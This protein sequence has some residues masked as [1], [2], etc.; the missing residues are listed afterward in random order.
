MTGDMNR[1]GS[2]AT[3]TSQQAQELLA[4]IQ[5]ELLPAALGRLHSLTGLAK[6]ETRLAAYSALGALLLIA[7]CAFAVVIGWGL[8][9]ASAVY[10]AAKYS[11]AILLSTVIGLVLL[12]FVLARVCWVY[13]IALTR[14]LSLPRL[15]EALRS[16]ADE[17]ATH[18]YSA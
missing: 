7:L 11:V 16:Q 3:A 1:E 9:V 12:H 15:R 5:T 4:V 6:A 2:G 8:L 13:A 14:N 18:R 10:A 17:L